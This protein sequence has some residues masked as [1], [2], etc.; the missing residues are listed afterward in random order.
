MAA[1]HRCGCGEGAAGLR[2]TSWLLVK[3]P[4]EGL[5]A[6]QWEFPNVLVAEHKSDETVDPGA[7]ARRGAL[8]EMLALL[9]LGG[10]DALRGRET[11]AAEVEHIFSHVRHTMHVERAAVPRAA[12][13]SDGVTD[14]VTGGVT[15]G[16]TDGVVWSHGGRE[17][18]WLDEAAMARVGVTAGVKKVIGAVTAHA[19]PSVAKAGGGKRKAAAAADGGGAGGANQPKLSSFF[20]KKAD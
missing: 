20:G 15:G 16:V 11:V 14:G 6:G 2:S 8:D 7:E 18:C 19:A 9:G 4:A 17:L 5:L 13:D 10:G 3:R 12:A 1:L